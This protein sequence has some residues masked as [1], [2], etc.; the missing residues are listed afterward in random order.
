MNKS[1][2]SRCT[3]MGILLMLAISSFCAAQQKAEADVILG[4]W[5]TDEKD[6][7]VEIFKCEEAYCGKI[8]WLKEQEKDGKPVL[9]AQNAHEELRSRPVMGLEVLMDFIYDKNNQWKKG[10]LYSPKEGSSYKGKLELDGNNTLKV[11]G[12]LGPLK[13]TVQWQRIQKPGAVE[14]EDR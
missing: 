7:H 14:Q 2:L 4:L 6:A 1:S 9:D 5:L 10:H 3:F 13:R 11:T 12:Y 8:V